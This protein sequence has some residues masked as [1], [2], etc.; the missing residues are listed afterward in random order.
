M[1]ACDLLEKCVKEFPNI[2]KSHE[3]IMY[4]SM[5]TNEVNGAFHYIIHYNY[6]MPSLSDKSY[7]SVVIVE[8]QENLFEN[9]FTDDLYL[10]H[11]GGLFS[12]KKKDIGEK[13]LDII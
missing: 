5:F 6:T 8:C 12:L 3:N 4:D 1:R 7:S 10:T 2:F 9:D 11:N 13:I